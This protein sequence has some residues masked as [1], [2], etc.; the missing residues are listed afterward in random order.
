MSENAFTE[1]SNESAQGPEYA[2]AYNLLYKYKPRLI[3]RFEKRDLPFN[4]K[5]AF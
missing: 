1:Q 2:L 4:G 5:S 3:Q